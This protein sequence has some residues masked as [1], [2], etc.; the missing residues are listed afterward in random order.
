MTAN[1]KYRAAELLMSL[2][3]SYEKAN[4]KAIS[5]SPISEKEVNDGVTKLLEKI[6][7][8][9]EKAILNRKSDFYLYYYDLGSSRTPLEAFAL[10]R[11]VYF[12]LIPIL[13]ELDFKYKGGEYV[14][15]GPRLTIQVS[16]M[17]YLLESIKDGT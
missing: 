17:I 9:F 5:F 10:F 3:S 16:K 13:N 14:S 11:L 1:S 7:K 4:A 12:K 15:S 2:K 8:E 6:V